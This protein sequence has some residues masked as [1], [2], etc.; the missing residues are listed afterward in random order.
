MVVVLFALLGSGSWFVSAATTTSTLFAKN[1]VPKT[2]TASDNKA[3]ELGVRFK[4]SV[5]G[6]VTGVR[7]YKG[8]QNIG[9]HSGELWD[10]Q[11]DLLAEAT[12][13][14]ET[15]S[16]WQTV[17]FSQPVQ[18]AA[19]VPYVVSYYAPQGHYSY[20]DNYFTKAHSKG[21]LTALANTST[22]GNGLY[23]YSSG[24]AFPTHTYKADNYWVDVL[25]NTK[26]VGSTAKPAPPASLQA[27]QEQGSIQLTWPASISAKP[28]T[29]YYVLRNGTKI[30]TVSGSTLTYNDTSVTAGTTYSYQIE[31]VDNAGTVSAASV[32]ATVTYNVTP[33]TPTPTPTPTPSPTPTPTPTPPGTLPAAGS[34]VKP[35]TVGYLGSTSALTL[36]QSGG[37]TPS[38]CSWQSY[39]LRCDQDDLTLDHVHIVGGLYWT[40]TGSLTVTNSIVEGSAAWYGVYA[41]AVT[42]NANSVIKVTDSTLRWAPGQTE[43]GGQDV[44][45][46]WTRGTQAFDI[47][48]CDIS[49]MPQGLDPGANSVIKNNWIHDL[50][51]NTPGSNPSHIDGIFSQG[52]SNILIEGNY[53]DVPVRGDTTAAMFIQNRGDTDTGIRIWGN[54]MNGGAYT[55]RNQT[56]I[57]VDVQNNTFGTGLYGLIG[58]LTGYPGTYGTWNGNVDATGKAIV[59]P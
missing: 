17:S 34:Y 50:N 11:G 31:A 26:V 19:N 7:F 30:A 15:S 3:V 40:G 14:N 4:A 28:L 47:E 41:A 1:A 18:I 25:F 55:L 52:G 54:Y 45:P 51:Q 21:K 24:T 13:K 22:V 58:D 29:N 23:V 49:G 46:V 42:N 16:G 10:N 32:T 48:R 38:G 20:N 8:A 9:T 57:G 53:I 2:I 59:K 43:P 12:F 5:A 56:G 39:G 27:T 37:A 6:Q 35:G 33:P 44:G 36:Y